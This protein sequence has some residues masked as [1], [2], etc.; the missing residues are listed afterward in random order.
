MIVRA[1][2]RMTDSVIGQFVREKSNWIA[3][4]KKKVEE[5]DASHPPMSI[6]EGGQL[7]YMGEEYGVVRSNAA[8]I[9]ISGKI[10][11]IPRC[12]DMSQVTAWMKAE[13][14]HIIRERVYHYASVTKLAPKSIRLTNARTRWGSCGGGGSLNFTWRLVM[15]PLSVIDYVVVHELCHIVHRNHGRLFWESVEKILPRYREA[16]RWLKDNAKLIQMM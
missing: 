7:M 15:C 1:P 14:S 12:Y 16:E 6:S 2:L 9:A 3:K 13:A 11:S 4:A 10:I 5:Y 8:D